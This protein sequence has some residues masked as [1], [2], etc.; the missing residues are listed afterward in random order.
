MEKNNLPA[1]PELEKFSTVKLDY[2]GF[3]L[4]LKERDIALLMATRSTTKMTVQDIADSYGVTRDRIY[5]LAR[6]DD[7]KR[8]QQHLLE[9]VFDELFGKAVQ[10]LHDIMDNSKSDALKLKAIQMI[11]SANGKFKHEHSITVEPP[12]KP[13]T[14]EELEVDRHRRILEIEELEKELLDGDL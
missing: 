3:R 2:D 7:F 13:M 5:K 4:T 10:S 11:L 14:L 12:K 8:F 6:Q 1:L 9:E